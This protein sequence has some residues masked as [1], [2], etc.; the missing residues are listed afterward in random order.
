MLTKGAQTAC[1]RASSA[2][3]ALLDRLA[4]LEGRSVQLY[5]LVLGGVVGRLQRLSLTD[6][7]P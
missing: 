6:R 2:R 7:A 4:G 1:Q 5:Q 3:L